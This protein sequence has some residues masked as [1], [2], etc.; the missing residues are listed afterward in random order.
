MRKRVSGGTRDLILNRA[1]GL[2]QNY[3]K[4][5]NQDREDSAPAP[6][7]MT[8]LITSGFSRSSRRTK[9]DLQKWEGSLAR[10]TASCLQSSNAP[11]MP[12]WL[13]IGRRDT[14]GVG[15]PTQ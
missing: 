5:Q 12:L 4:D 7:S 1:G 2:S 13:L 9:G 3:D 15:R 8:S 6:R 11:L 14:I 10:V